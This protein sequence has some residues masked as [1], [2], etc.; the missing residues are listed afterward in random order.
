MK[1]VVILSRR[2]L[3]FRKYRLGIS[4]ALLEVEATKRGKKKDLVELANKNAK[5]ALEE[6]FYL[7]ER[8]EERTIKAVDR[9]GSGLGLK[10]HIV[11]KRLI[12]QIFKEQIRFCN[13]CFYRWETGEE[14][15]SKI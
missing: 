7:I 1:T 4:R 6:K 5:I 11:L 10:R 8:D 14:R 2:R 13:D 15:V 3:S 9:L 12:T